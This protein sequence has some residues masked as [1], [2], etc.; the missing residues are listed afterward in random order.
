MSSS[1]K[2]AVVYGM[3]CPKVCPELEDP[4]CAFSTTN[5]YVNFSSQCFLTMANCKGGSEYLLGH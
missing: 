2:A 3:D 1:V 4:L 5:G